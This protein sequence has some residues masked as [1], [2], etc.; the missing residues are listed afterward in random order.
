MSTPSRL[1]SSTRLCRWG[2]VDTS[3]MNHRP[4]RGKFAFDKITARSVSG[5]LTIQVVNRR[6]DRSDGR[7]EA[8]AWQKAKRPL[9]EEEG[10]GNRGAIS[11]RESAVERRP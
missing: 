4:E 2:I 3:I 9:E 1:A 5:P 7:A 8:T 6:V 11:R 10:H